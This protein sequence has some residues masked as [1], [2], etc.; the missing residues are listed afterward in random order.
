MGEVRKELI[1]NWQNLW[2]DN[3]KDK[4]TYS[5]IPNVGRF[6]WDIPSQIVQLITDH[7]PFP[8]YLYR[9]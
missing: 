8:A 4:E 9:N 3:S 7:G 1:S 5:L 6:F 2:D